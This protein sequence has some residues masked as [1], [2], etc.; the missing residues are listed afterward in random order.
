MSSIET[1]DPSVLAEPFTVSMSTSR[2]SK[3]PSKS[4]VIQKPTIS[5]YDEI[6]DAD[7]DASNAEPEKDET[8]LELER[9]VFGD[10][11]G[12]R[13]ELARHG[14]VE[15]GAESAEGGDEDRDLDAVAD[16]DV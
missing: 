12:F 9:L 11:D 6:S 1:I 7:A 15:S 5:A 4:K 8:E 10:D 16:A 3:P 13:K 2:V 14:D